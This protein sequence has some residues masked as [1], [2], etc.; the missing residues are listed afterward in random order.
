VL[1]AVK[2]RPREVLGSTCNISANTAVTPCDFAV[3]SGE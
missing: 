1:K 2:I 3:C